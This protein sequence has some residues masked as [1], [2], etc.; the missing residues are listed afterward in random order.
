[1]M[2]EL[3]FVEA[4]VDEHFYAMSLIHALGWRDTYED[5]VPTEWMAE[6]VTDDRWVDT[7]RGYAR[8]G[9]KHG[10]LLYRGETPVSLLN[11][12]EK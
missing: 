10:L 8:E 3:R 9:T 4:S 7:F 5:A 1:M 2:E 12:V 6:H 11:T